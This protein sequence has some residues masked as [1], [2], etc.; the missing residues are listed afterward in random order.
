[1]DF[2]EGEVLLINK[3]LEWT[4]FDVVNKIRSIIRGKLNIKKIKVGHAGTLD[5]LATGLLLVCT[6]KMTKQIDSFQAQKKE[7]ITTIKL[8]ATTPSFD[9]ETAEDYVFQYEHIT[10]ELFENTLKQFIGEIEQT[11]PMF[12]AKKVDGQK[13]YIAARKGLEIDLKPN[14]ITI[15][16]IEILDFKLPYVQIKVDCSKGTYIRALGRDI[17]KALNSGA[18]LTELIRTKIGEFNVENAIEILEFEK[19]VNTL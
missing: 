17:G 6:G 12:S 8:G 18:Y 15:N 10:R 13:A 14:K 3:P 5:P 2:I 11:P 7:Y 16:S 1:V 4:S 9:R 19:K